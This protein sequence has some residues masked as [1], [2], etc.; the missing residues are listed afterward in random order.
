MSIG[1]ELLN[2]LICAKYIFL[3]GMD[4]FNRGGPFSSGLA[5]L[6][7]QDATEMVVRV[8][9]EY[10][11]CPLKESA[12]FNQIIDAIDNI[13]DKRLTHRSALNQLNKARVNFKHFGLEP[14][15][16]DVNKFICDLEGFFPSV[17]RSFLDI[18][19]ESISLANLIG[20]KRTENFLH[21]AERLIAEGDYEGA[22]RA[23]AIAFTIFRAYSTTDFER[24]RRDPFLRFKDQDIQRWANNIEEAIAKQQSQLNVIIDG[25]NLADYR[26][27]QRYTPVVQLFMG[28]TFQV[29]SGFGEPIEP[30]KDIALFSYRFVIEALLLMGNNRLPPRFPVQ[31]PKRKFQIVKRCDVIVWPCENPEIIRQ[32]DVGEILYGWARSQVRDSD[33]T[34]Y[35]AIVQD[36]DD[37][38]VKKDAVISFDEGD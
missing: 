37:A 14:K 17:L 16:E 23:I 38:Y 18:D 21:K 6:N 3:K 19:F 28:G 30:T 8:I 33:T 29:Y 11:H 22:I 1:K 12:S 24:F 26:R 32:A 31:E 35:V 20:H 9:A 5:V 2:R 27:F 7:F 15:E 34:D 10:L 25:I 13:S 36:F 4:V